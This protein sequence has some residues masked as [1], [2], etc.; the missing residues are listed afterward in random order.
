MVTAPWGNRGK[1]GPNSLRT[2]FGAEQHV[3]RVGPVPLHGGTSPAPGLTSTEISSSSAPPGSVA[4][5]ISTHREKLPVFLARWLTSGMVV[6]PLTQLF[7]APRWIVQTSFSKCRPVREKI[8]VQPR[9]SA[10]TASAARDVLVH[11]RHDQ[12]RPPVRAMCAVGSTN[13]FRYVPA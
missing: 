5:A 13:Q 12:L 1:P 10:T 8:E 9:S 7:A 2:R 4:V 11:E 6:C 3:P